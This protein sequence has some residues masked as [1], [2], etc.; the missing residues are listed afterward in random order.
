MAVPE[1]GVWGTSP[2]LLT[3]TPRAAHVA[4]AERRHPIR[5]VV[6]G[7]VPD[8]DQVISQ[9]QVVPRDVH[10]GD[11]V[12][13]LAILGYW[14]HYTD[15]T[16]AFKGL[17]ARSGRR[18]RLTR[19]PA[20]WSEVLNAFEQSVGGLQIVEHDCGVYDDPPTPHDLGPNIDEHTYR[21]CSPLHC[22]A[23][24]GVCATCYG[25]NSATSGLPAI[26]EPVGKRAI[27][28]LRNPAKAPFRETKVFR[29]GSTV[30]WIVSDC[31]G[32]VRFDIPPVGVVLA[33]ASDYVA[34]IAESWA[35]FD[36]DGDG[37]E[38]TL[39]I[40][41]AGKEY[42]FGNE[43]RI[44]VE[45]G[46][47]VEA[48]T[49]L[50]YRRPREAQLPF[51]ADLDGLAR[52]LDFEMPHPRAVLSPFD[53]TLLICRD[54][55]GRKTLDVFE[56]VGDRHWRCVLEEVEDTGEPR[57][58]SGCSVGA[59][60]PLTKGYPDINDEVSILGETEAFF[61]YFGKILRLLTQRR[62]EVSF[63]GIRL[64]VS[65]LFRWR[66]VE[67]P[68]DS[69]WTT[70]SVVSRPAFERANAEIHARGGV[71]AIGRSWFV[72]ARELARLVRQP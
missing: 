15:P 64:I 44:V 55:V 11:G 63:D 60:V 30:D 18:D 26:G 6:P 35:V 34:L 33:R 4:E 41:G 69:G 17:E 28:S 37:G 38:Q 5:A 67:D 14:G 12:D 59:G 2:F 43:D 10:L 19:K 54:E 25:Y 24:D 32:K 57:F 27:E 70:D 52:M 8:L 7:F 23:R 29:Y 62:M 40:E 39:R 31:A 71:P 13:D 21:V 66:R 51:L 65:R 72:G 16:F 68:G 3:F 9:L 20:T 36:L 1:S 22:R 45:P 61:W 53:G 49:R 58:E 56:E 48:G 47:F 50:G 46:E 42:R